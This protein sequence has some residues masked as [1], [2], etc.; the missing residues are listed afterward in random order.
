MNLPTDAKLSIFLKKR[1]LFCGKL[2]NNYFCRAILKKTTILYGYRSAI[3]IYHFEIMRMRI[4]YFVVFCLTLFPWLYSCGDKSHKANDDVY[5]TTDCDTLTHYARFLTIADA[6][7]GIVFV[8]IADPWHDDSY[9]ARYAFIHRDS[10]IPNGVTAHRLLVRTPVNRIA[11]F[12]SIHTDGINELGAISTLAA[13]ADGMFF[14]DTDTVSKLITTG[15]VIDVGSYQAPSSEK[16]AMARVEAV[17]RSPM[18]GAAT[19]QL[20]QG[21]V[22]IECADYLETSPIARAE[23]LLLLGE[24]TGKRAEANEIFSNVIE[25]YSSLSQKATNAS[26]PKPKVLTECEESGVWYVPANESY[27]ASMI[28]DAGGISPWS[29]IKGTGSAPLGFEK[30][31]ERCIDADIWLL[32]TFGFSPD[33]NWLVAQNTRYAAFKAV[34]NNNVYGCDS[35]VKPIFNDLAFHPERILADYVAIFHPDVMPEYELKYFTK[36]KPNEK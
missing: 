12:S 27:M 1:M 7:C 22:P 36:S 30:V 21:I 5:T 25:R 16:L 28:R 18:Q 15:K 8:D 31:A 13:V 24:L 4:E 20:P 11:V 19:A 14:L 34:K 2:K 35:S 17:L 3:L 32:R 29:D 9:L 33:A 23:W 26:S 10:I 6:G